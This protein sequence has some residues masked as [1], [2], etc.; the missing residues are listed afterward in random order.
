MVVSV[1][2]LKNNDCASEPSIPPWKNGAVLDRPHRLV[3]ESE[4]HADQQIGID[5]PQHG[6]LIDIML[7]TIERRIDI[8]AMKYSMAATTKTAPVTALP[9]SPNRV[10][11]ATR[12]AIART[13]SET[14]RTGLARA[15]R[16]ARS[17][18]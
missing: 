5:R 13:P 2:K 18:P 4:E 16:E 11:I 6:F 1:V 8:G 10:V 9:S 14:R 17:T 15:T 7:Q 3:G 12:T